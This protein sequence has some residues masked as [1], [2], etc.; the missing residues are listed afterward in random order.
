[1]SPSTSNTRQDEQHE[2]R[3]LT[4]V[5]PP[6]YSD[7]LRLDHVKP[8]PEYGEQK[9]PPLP[10]PIMS[11]FDPAHPPSPHDYQGYPPPTVQSG[12]Q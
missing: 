3:E 9:E 5:A 6:S 7:A 8:P 11:N 12:I 10:Y 1:M 4:K 2:E